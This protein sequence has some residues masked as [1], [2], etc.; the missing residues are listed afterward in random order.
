MHEFS[1]THSQLRV[2]HVGYMPG[3][4]PQ[5]LLACLCLNRNIELVRDGNDPD[6]PFRLQ[7]LMTQLPHKRMGE[8]LQGRRLDCACASM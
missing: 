3:Q 2:D 8:A 5:D 1:D 6:A 4:Q 7:L